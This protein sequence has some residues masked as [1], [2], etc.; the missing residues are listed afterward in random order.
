[1]SVSFFCYGRLDARTDLEIVAY[2]TPYGTR[3][4][5][6]RLGG[7]IFSRPSSVRQSRAGGHFWPAL[8]TG[9]PEGAADSRCQDAPNEYDAKIDWEI[10]NNN[11]SQPGS[12]EEIYPSE[13]IDEHCK[14][15][16]GLNYGPYKRVGNFGDVQA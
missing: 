3:S 11:L 16:I 2:I 7:H 9:R 10:V 5:Y 8:T 6:F 12:L 14:E 1:M 4:R 13:G 15:S